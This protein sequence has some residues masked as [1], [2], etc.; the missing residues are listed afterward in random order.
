MTYVIKD[1]DVN[2]VLHEKFEHVS[3][4]VASS[5]VQARQATLN[6]ICTT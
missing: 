1:R 5:H 6:M 4:T 2:R 3:V